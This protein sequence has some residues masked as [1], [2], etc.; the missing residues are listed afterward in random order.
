MLVGYVTGSEETSPYEFLVRVRSKPEDL[1]ETMLKI[2][3]IL[4]T[5][6]YYPNHGRITIYAM[7]T[8]IF[9]SWDG[10]YITGFEESMMIEKKLRLQELTAL[11]DMMTGG[12]FL[13]HLNKHGK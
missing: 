4:K 7:V 11:I 2:G 13:E 3:D 1:P 6:F 10:D 12:Y 8:E 9:S 5:S